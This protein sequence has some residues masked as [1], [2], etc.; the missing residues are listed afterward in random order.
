M[1]IV[2]YKAKTKKAPLKTKIRI[3]LPKSKLKYLDIGD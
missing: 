3:R 2:T 1:N